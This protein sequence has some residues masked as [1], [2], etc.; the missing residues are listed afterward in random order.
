MT[1]KYQMLLEKGHCLWKI[2]N[3]EAV[4]AAVTQEQD[5]TQQNVLLVI[6]EQI[7]KKCWKVSKIKKTL[8]GVKAFVL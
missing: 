4:A 6:S 3:G 8:L 7:N 2:Q 1:T 5:L